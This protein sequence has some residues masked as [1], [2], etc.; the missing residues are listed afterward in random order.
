MFGR[1]E[2]RQ[3]KQ[4]KFIRISNMALGLVKYSFGINKNHYHCL[5][6]IKKQKSQ[7]YVHILSGPP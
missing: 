6:Y 3:Y 5:A 2:N 4:L 1:T 7:K